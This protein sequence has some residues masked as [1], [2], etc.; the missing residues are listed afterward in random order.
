MRNAFII[1]GLIAGSAFFPALG[2]VAAVAIIAIAADRA[3]SRPPTPRVGDVF[4]DPELLEDIRKLE[5]KNGPLYP[6]RKKQ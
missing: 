4:T 2:I 1:A 5:A 3:Y 6:R